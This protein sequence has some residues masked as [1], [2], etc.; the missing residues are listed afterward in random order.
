MVPSAMPLFVGATLNEMFEQGID[1]E[2]AFKETLG[3]L[4][5]I[6]EPAFNLTMLDGVNRGCAICF[7]ERKRPHH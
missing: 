1:P 7:L 3:A 5:N 4:S 2:N 6:M